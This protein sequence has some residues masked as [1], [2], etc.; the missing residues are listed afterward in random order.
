MAFVRVL[1][2]PEPNPSVRKSNG[3]LKHLAISR[4]PPLGCPLAQH[5]LLER[6]VRILEVFL[7]SKRGGGLQDP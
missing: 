7:H 2:V 5:D 4:F 6:S 1:T 3:T